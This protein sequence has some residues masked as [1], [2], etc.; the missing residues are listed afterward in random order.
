MH[1]VVELGNCNPLGKHPV[2]LQD[3]SLLTVFWKSG[4][5]ASKCVVVLQV[6]RLDLNE[7]TPVALDCV[8][9]FKRLRC[10]I[11]TVHLA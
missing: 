5:V 11:L 6:L 2:C 3:M 9:Y 7:T 10:N 8:L 4:C 1:T